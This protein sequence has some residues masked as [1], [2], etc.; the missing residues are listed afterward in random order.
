MLGDD[1]PVLTNNEKATSWFS[2]DE[3]ITI[4]IDEHENIEKSVY[5]GFTNNSDPKKVI[6]DEIDAL[7]H[8]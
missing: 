7:A 5:S 2:E 6:G 3:N 1:E 8:E 4:L